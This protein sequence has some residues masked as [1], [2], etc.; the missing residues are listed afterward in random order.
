M[1][2]Y[3]V[4][5]S[6]CLATTMVAKDN[7]IEIGISTGKISA[8]TTSYVGSSSSSSSGSSNAKTLSIGKYLTD[9]DIVAFAKTFVDTE[10]NQD[11]NI[12]S[13]AY[14]RHIDTE[15]KSNI[16]LFAGT[17]F[18]I[19]ETRFWK[20]QD[21]N[22]LYHSNSLGWYTKIISLDFGVRVAEVAKNL[23]IDVGYSLGLFH[24]GSGSIGYDATTAKFEHD[25]YKQWQVGLNYKF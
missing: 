15:A 9:N 7:S 19:L 10:K 23:S 5:V 17:T 4:I 2:K 25:K 21:R 13:L 8:T 14:R 24:S 1:K 20:I 6:M 22:P 12:M 11:L 3:I 18:T 16:K